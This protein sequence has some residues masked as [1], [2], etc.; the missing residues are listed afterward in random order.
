MTDCQNHENRTV[1][2]YW[3]M[4]SH[5]QAEAAHKVFRT[6]RTIYTWQHDD[7]WSAHQT[8]AAD[9]WMQDVI[10]A[11]RKAVLDQLRAGDGALGLKILE[12]TEPALSPAP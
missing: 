12:R 4:M 5:S 2:A 8:A 3:L 10:N 1:A 11:S 7:C 9:R 6:A